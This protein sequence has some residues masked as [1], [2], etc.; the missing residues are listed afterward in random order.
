MSNINLYTLSQKIDTLHDNIM[1]KTIIYLGIHVI[2][3]LPKICQSS[4]TFVSYQTHL[5]V[6]PL[7][8]SKL[9]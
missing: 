8:T 1:A 6:M 7:R 2:K 3:G 9:G 4:S 5:T